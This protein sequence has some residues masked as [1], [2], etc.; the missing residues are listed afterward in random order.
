MERYLLRNGIPFETV[1]R[2]KLN[3]ERISEA[4]GFYLF[5]EFIS[6][7]EEVQILEEIDSQSWETSERDPSRR[8]LKFDQNS[9]AFPSFTSKICDRILRDVNSMGLFPGL[10]TYRLGNVEHTGLLIN[11]Y[12]Q[13]DSLRFH[14]DD[15]H[16]YKELL[17]GLSMGCD[18]VFSLLREPKRVDILLP[19]R[20]LYVLSG[21]SRYQFKHG[22]M[23]GGIK[24]ERRVSITVRGI[25]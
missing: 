9:D 11:E 12:N 10:G 8:S 18:C 22:I 24:G 5:P 20:S 13:K 6:K 15:R 17:F 1:K 7:E 25:N 3:Y 14:F 21:Q 16:M 19:A 2:R 4:P 23:K